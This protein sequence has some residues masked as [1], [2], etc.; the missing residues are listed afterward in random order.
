[1]SGAE[2]GRPAE[3]LAILDVALPGAE[4]SAEFFG[5]HARRAHRMKPVEGISL[6]IGIRQALAEPELTFSDGTAAAAT[7]RPPARRQFEDIR[8]ER[9]EERLPGSVKK[10][11][12]SGG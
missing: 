7:F 10:P 8:H 9:I 3:P 4:Q 12:G 5:A 2:V 1:M 11:E 6:C